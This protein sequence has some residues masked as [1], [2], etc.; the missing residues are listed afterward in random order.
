MDAQ[1]IIKTYCRS[2]CKRTSHD[3]LFEHEKETDPEGYHEIDL[4]QIV[5][6]RGCET[7]GFR[8]QND[9]FEQFVE[10]DDGTVS[11]ITSVTSYPR[12]IRGHRRLSATW[13]LPSLIHKIYKQ[14]LSAYGENAYVL[15]SIG[16]RATIEAACNHLE[17]SGSTLERRID[18][19]FKGGYV[20]NADK[21]RLHAIRFLGND[22]AHEV[23]EPSEK[24]L[25]VALEI[26]EHLLNSVFILEH[27]AKSLKTVIESYEEFKDL[28]AECVDELNPT[29]AVSIGALLS[30]HRRRVGNSIDAFET[31]LKMEI[32]IGAVPFLSLAQVEKVSGKDVQLYNV[33][34]AT[35]F[36]EDGNADEADELEL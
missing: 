19:L 20:S 35:G 5:Q 2:C 27:K 28:L 31:Q 13:W 18:Q 11:H 24:D 9:D 25:R 22:A 1:K 10:E 34:N 7:M 30:N 29:Q 4:W 12:V 14:T 21:R 36:A 17:I 8:H 15:A 33:I 16:L 26:V 3:V 32:D 23:K 6:C